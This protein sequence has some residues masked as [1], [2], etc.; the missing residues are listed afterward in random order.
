MIKNKQI[1]MESNRKKI[2]HNDK[3]R[4]QIGEDRLG[5]HDGCDECDVGLIDFTVVG[6]FSISF[7]SSW[8]RVF[9]I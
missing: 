6:F 4:F 7:S 1:E 2:N 8:P 9:K 5:E 3:D